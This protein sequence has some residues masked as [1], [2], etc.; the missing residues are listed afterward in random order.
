MQETAAN[1]V[2]DETAVSNKLKR[3]KDLEMENFDF[4]D[5]VDFRLTDE[6]SKKNI[7]RFAM[8]GLYGL[9]S[10]VVIVTGAHAIMLVMAQAPAAMGAENSLLAKF[11]NAIRIAFPIVVEAAAV[12]AGLGFIGAKWRK[13]QK[14]AAFGI[15]LTWVLF[16]AANMITFFRIERGLP[17]ETWQV[18][19]VDYGLP[20]SALIAGIL[21]Y[22]LT[23]TDPDLKRKDEETAAEEK[24]KMI[25]F[26]SRR[27]V[28]ISAQRQAIEK[29]RAWID[30]I[31]MLET[32]GYS[33]QQIRFMLQGVPE[34]LI[35]ADFDGQLDLLESGESPQPTR[36]VP[37]QQPPQEVPAARPTPAP[38]RN[39]SGAGFNY[40]KRDGYSPE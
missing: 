16:A 28:A 36:A 8:A 3:A 38:A 13:G 4:D 15:E 37:A 29:Q 31:K 6:E 2:T 12:V 34:L 5:N 26:A 27:D 9:L 30:F 40:P 22:S 39:G 35:D 21:T 1:I 19:W 18:S 10:I 24:I 33:Q 20:L 11:L 14:T 7:K 25:Q 32:K 17:L 23:R